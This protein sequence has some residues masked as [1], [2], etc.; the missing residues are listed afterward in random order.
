MQP[1]WGFMKRLCPMFKNPP[2]DDEQ[3]ASHLWNILP[4]SARAQWTNVDQQYIDQ[5]VELALPCF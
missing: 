2:L 1:F 5:H 4:P 3:L